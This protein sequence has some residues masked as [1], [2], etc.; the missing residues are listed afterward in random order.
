[1]TYIYTNEDEID[2]ELKCSICNEPFQSPMNCKSCGNTYCQECIMQW[3]Q[4]QL[5]CPSCRQIG[6][7]FLPV[8]SRVVLNQLN[9]LLVQCT[10]CQQMN[11]Q[12]SNFNDHISCTCPRQIVNCIDN[13][14]WK[15]CRENLQEHL[16]ECRRKQL[17][18]D[19]ISKYWK[20]I[21]FVILAILFFYIIKP[22]DNKK[23]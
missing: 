4:Q 16:I 19:H 6:N 14:G 9:R 17:L 18:T 13:C 20:N 10:L 3:M 22:H 5:S 1:M 21:A 15:G 12:R 2:I 11:I 23:Y 8:I 7:Q